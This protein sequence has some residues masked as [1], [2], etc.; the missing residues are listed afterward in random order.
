MPL[1][2]DTLIDSSFRYTKANANTNINI[3][4]LFVQMHTIVEIKKR[5]KK[6]NEKIDR[7]EYVLL[8]GS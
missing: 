7:K 5:K 1:Q 2:P 6:S 8:G 3:R 4:V